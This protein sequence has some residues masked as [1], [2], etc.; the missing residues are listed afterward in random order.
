LWS[1]HGSVEKQEQ[2]QVALHQG[3]TIQRITF[4]AGPGLDGGHLHRKAALTRC[5]EL[6]TL[7]AVDGRKGWA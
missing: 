2:I 4:P 6:F 3:P 7:A 5:R 1:V